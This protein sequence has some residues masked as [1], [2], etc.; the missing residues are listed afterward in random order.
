MGTDS[1]ASVPSAAQATSA[2]SPTSYTPARSQVSSGQVKYSS[3]VPVT[4]QLR[5]AVAFPAR[6]RAVRRISGV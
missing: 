2:I 1:G 5:E 3:S 4:V 6:R